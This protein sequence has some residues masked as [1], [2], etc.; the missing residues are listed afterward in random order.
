M[1]LNIELYY[2]HYNYSISL[3]ST[4][5]NLIVFS[6]VTAVVEG[7]ALLLNVYYICIP[8]F[9]LFFYLIEYDHIEL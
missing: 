8:G 1:Y 7:G 2:L 9:L 5:T 3:E 6:I 4:H